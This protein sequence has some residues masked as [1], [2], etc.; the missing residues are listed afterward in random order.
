MHERSILENLQA[1][2]GEQLRVTWGIFLTLFE[3]FGFGH[4]DDGSKLK[5]VVCMAFTPILL[6]AAAIIHDTRA[7]AREA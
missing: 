6:F 7:I 2:L 1:A 5:I 3:F 4:L